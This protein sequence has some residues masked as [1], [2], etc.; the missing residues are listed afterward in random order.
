MQPPG[1][2]QSHSRTSGVSGGVAGVAWQEADEI[3]FRRY[4]LRLAPGKGVFF[5]SMLRLCR[6][7]TWRS[8]PWGAQARGTDFL[9]WPR[10]GGDA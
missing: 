7:G 4:A 8:F 2:S 3:R 5:W 9:R 6:V 1:P 10:A